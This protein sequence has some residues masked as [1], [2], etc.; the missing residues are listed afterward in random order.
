MT[1]SGTGAVGD[2]CFGNATKIAATLSGTSFTQQNIK[3]L[4]I[5]E[6]LTAI[7]PCAFEGLL[8]L[9][10]ELVIPASVE[11]VGDTFLEF[12]DVGIT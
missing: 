8:S 2:E 9:T 12:T 7:E 10:G 5:E 4:V 6:G 11:S 3:S 1:I